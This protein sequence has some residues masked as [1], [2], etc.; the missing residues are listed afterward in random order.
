[1][2]FNFTEDQVAIRDLAR[3]I[4]RDHASDEQVHAQAQTGAAY[5]TELWQ[6]F[7]EAGLLGVALPE[8]YGGIGLGI[9]ELC[10]ILEEQGRFV[11]P[12]PLYSALVL[13]GLS[14]AQFGSDQ[15]KDILLTGLA[16]GEH[17]LTGAF[18]ELGMSPAGIVPMTATADGAG[19][20]LT[21]VRQAV[22]FAAQSAAIVVPA[23]TETG[24]VLLLVKPDQAGVSLDEALSTN[25]QPCATLHADEVVIEAAAVLVDEARSDAA[26]N[27][28]EQHAQTA[29][30]AIQIGVMEESLKR[31][32]EYTTD[33]KQF[34]T[35]IAGFQSTTIRCADAYID[36]EATRSAYWK[37]LWL[38]AE[39]QEAL[40]NVW[41]AK[42]WA[43]TG[44]HRV[45][46]TAQHLHG[47]IG[48]DI[49]YPLHRFFLWT[50]QNTLSLGGSNQQLAK[51]GAQLA[52]AE[53]LE[54][55][56]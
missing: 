44:G 12:L 45:A 52:D 7:A 19:Y 8:A 22:P 1:M 21:G 9:T 30:V 5:D 48:S 17:L 23:Q 27:W 10:L 55:V 20:R 31:T 50:K 35:A 33:R 53:Q 25:G 49:D 39:G 29:L 3:Q 46:H 36:V 4:L 40:A 56:I 41:A 24:T 15:Q 51:I 32:A 18:A 11:A 26:I 42:W 54:A 16:T 28:I 43:S 37:A 47:G 13:G 6:Q 34:G 38:L 14:V 2:D